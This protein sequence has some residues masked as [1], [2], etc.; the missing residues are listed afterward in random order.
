MKISGF[1]YSG[2]DVSQKISDRIVFQLRASLEGVGWTLM[3]FP[4]PLSHSSEL[5]GN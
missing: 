2:A 1:N 3:F 4:L 5:F